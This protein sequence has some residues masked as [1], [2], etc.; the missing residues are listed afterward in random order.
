MASWR[1]TELYLILGATP[2]V[3]LIF[4]MS[5]VTAG[6]AITFETLAV[7]IGLFAAFIAAHFAVCKLAPKAD[8]AMLPIT[9]LLSGVGIAFVFR[10]APE[11]ATSQL[12]WLFLAIALMV[13]TLVV[14]RSI[15]KV[16]RYK[17]TIMLVGLVLLLLP[18]VVGT[19][20]YGSKIWLS[21][22][23]FSFQ[24]GE[25]AKILIF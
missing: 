13:L 1:T 12:I 8:N 16:A 21:I 25:I 20:F 23:G 3:A 7:P 6:N 17:Y 4:I 15:A 18:A 24:P 5:I 14:V 9:Y 11:L 10:L 2:I 22:G 19:E